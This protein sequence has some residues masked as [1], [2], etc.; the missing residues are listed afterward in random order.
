MDIEKSLE[1]GI[2]NNIIYP[3]C[4]VQRNTYYMW[5]I[6]DYAANSICG[7]LKDKKGIKS[8]GARPV[9]VSDSANVTRE[10]ENSRRRYYVGSESSRLRRNETA[11]LLI[12]GTPGELYELYESLEKNERDHI[13]FL[14]IEYG[15]SD[16]KD[17]Y[18]INI[19]EW[20]IRV[21]EG[22]LHT[23]AN[24]AVA[25]LMD[26]AFS[27][28]L[29]HKKSGRG[30]R[31][32]RIEYKEYNA[33][34]E[35]ECNCFI[36]RWNRQVEDSGHLKYEEWQ[37]NA[38]LGIRKL[39]ECVCEKCLCPDVLPV[40][41]YEK[42]EEELNKKFRF[43]IFLN[44]A[45]RRLTGT[46]KE[47]VTEYKIKEVLKILFEEEGGFLRTEWLRREVVQG[48]MPEVCNRFLENEHSQLR[49]RINDC[50][51]LYDIIYT[52]SAQM[53]HYSETK[54]DQIRKVDTEIEENLGQIF[55]FR[56]LEIENILE[57]LKQYFRLWKEYVVLYSEC[58]IWESMSNFAKG[59]S[60]EIEKQYE[61]AKEAVQVLEKLKIPLSDSLKVS[62]ENDFVLGEKTCMNDFLQ[63][64]E[65]Y[66]SHASFKPG[67][68]ENIVK[69][70]DSEYQETVLY[71]VSLEKRPDI[72][73]ILNEALVPIPKK[74]DKGF[75]W[76]LKPVKYLPKSLLIE[77][78]MFFD[79]EEDSCIETAD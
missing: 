12:I 40:V 26:A 73:L 27:Q 35:E 18:T 74:Q 79:I 16:R 69:Y 7:R 61:D 3:F 55:A 78:K 59:M 63:Q 17:R 13:E 10:L 65:S 41:G 68:V 53:G 19:Q 37:E 44:S 31:A 22:E 47:I 52:V 62:V 34:R 23:A 70:K 6:K 66:V 38:R 77:L 30:N 48:E 14:C 56:S 9:P 5:H 42:L 60:T 43:Q 45:L 51:T 64:M 36:E 20:R 46:S 2:E 21:R 72:Y 11:Y 75:S 28:E 25:L 4:N 54:K 29:L 71:H 15:I 32:V 58:L 33:V 57:N 67:D 24:A 8:A 1:I 49:K 39:A 50:F 76:N